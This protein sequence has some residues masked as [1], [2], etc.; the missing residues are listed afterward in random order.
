ME[1][2][3]EKI[4][5]TYYEELVEA[6]KRRFPFIKDIMFVR[7]EMIIT[8]YIQMVVIIDCLDMLQYYKIDEIPDV[9]DKTFMNRDMHNL[10]F[11][12][13]TFRMPDETRIQIGLDGEEIKQ[14]ILDISTL[15]LLD[16]DDVFKKQITKDKEVNIHN[17]KFFVECD[18]KD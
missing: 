13:H 11:A 3:M 12:F 7:D 18:V 6:A 5:S 2:V 9:V 10:S 4:N 15:F 17:V 14:D 1:N 16:M 8:V